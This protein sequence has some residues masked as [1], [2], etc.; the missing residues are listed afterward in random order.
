MGAAVEM[1]QALGTAPAR[2]AKR[3]IGWYHQA[4]ATKRGGTE[5][6]KSESTDSTAEVG[7]PAPGDPAEGSG[8]PDYG[9]S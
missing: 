9:A 4:K 1:V 3:S 7:E 6:E 2:G 8:G 5:G